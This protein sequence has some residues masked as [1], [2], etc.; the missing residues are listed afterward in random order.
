MNQAPSSSSTPG[1]NPAQSTSA[2]AGQ[3]DPVGHAQPAKCH[4]CPE[5]S[6]GLQPLVASGPDH[7]LTRFVFAIA[8]SSEAETESRSSSKRSGLMSNVMPADA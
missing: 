5:T 6:Q 2:A 4:R 1:R 7:I 8:R 3:E